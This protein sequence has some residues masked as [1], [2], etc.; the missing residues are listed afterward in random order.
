[1][2]T[3]KLN[4]LIELEDKVT[5]EFNNLTY[6]LD[7]SFQSVLKF[8][9]FQ[10]DNP[11]FED[12]KADKTLEFLSIFLNDRAED[13][14]NNV[15]KKLTLK[16][17]QKIL[18]EIVLVWLDRTVGSEQIKKISDQENKKKVIEN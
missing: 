6:E 14:H 4:E 10:K 17:S 3:I 1:M 8:E 2:A 16:N 5:L 9:Q 15:I 18:K 11:D 7:Q 13:F 12:I